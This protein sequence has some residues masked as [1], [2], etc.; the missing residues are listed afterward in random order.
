MKVIYLHGFASSGHSSKSNWLREQF[1]DSSFEFVSPD[2]PNKP[3]NAALF[4]ES[5][6]AD[7]AGEKVCLIGTS[8]GGFFAAFYAAK[9]DW[10]AV[11]I[12]PL[13]DIE[14]LTGT[15]MGENVNFA[16]GEQFIVDESD[17]VYLTRMSDVMGTSEMATLLLLDKGDELL[18]YQKALDRYGDRAQVML[19]EGG[20]HR[21]DHLD[22]AMDEINTLL[23]R[24]LFT[25]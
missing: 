24:Y 14:D 5:Y 22:E 23:S 20:S 17:G 16:T 11:L 13:A 21:F 19:Y 2:L 1:A 15:V 4:L 18:D 8:L 3:R 12:N 10:P 7:M 25:F 9:L 6:F